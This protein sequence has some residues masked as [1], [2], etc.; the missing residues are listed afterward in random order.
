MTLGGVGSGVR[1][2]VA[3]VALWATVSGVVLAIMVYTPWWLHVACGFHGRCEAFGVEAAQAHID[4]LSAFF[5]H[6]A[7]LEGRW[8]PKEI[9]HLTEVREIYDGLWWGWLAA[10]LLSVATLRRRHA[11]AVALTLAG[12]VLLVAATLP[13]FTFFWDAVFHELLFD[14]DLWLN[15]RADV[16]WWI[17]PNAFF[18]ASVVV[19]IGVWMLTI[20]ALWAWAAKAKP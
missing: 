13:A 20:A 2:A 4:N 7:T 9:A 15:T 1:V 17:M 3:A 11:R 10:A 8:T 6:Q 14:N 18:F 5:R 16:S 19:F 12:V